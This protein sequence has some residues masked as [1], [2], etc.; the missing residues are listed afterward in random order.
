MQVS[1]ETDDVSILH[2]I[3]KRFPLEDDSTIHFV[4]DPNAE[5]LRYKMIGIEGHEDQPTPASVLDEQFSIKSSS[6]VVTSCHGEE[7]QPP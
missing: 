3:N 6:Q 1:L 5:L 4:L 7:V 2:D